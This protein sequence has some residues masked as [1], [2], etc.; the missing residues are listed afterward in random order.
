MELTTTIK[1]NDV[2]TCI[3]IKGPKEAILLTTHSTRQLTST[4]YLWYNFKDVFFVLRR[5]L[6]KVNVTVFYT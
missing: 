3:L 5:N 4:S 6:L 2:L 1:D